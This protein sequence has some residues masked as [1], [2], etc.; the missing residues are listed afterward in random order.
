MSTIWRNGLRTALA[1]VLVAGGYLGLA[2]LLHQP[3]A[4]PYLVGSL[5]LGLAVERLWLLVRWLSPL[6]GTFGDPDQEVALVRAVEREL[7]RSLRYKAPLVVVAFHGRRKL[8]RQ[9]VA[10]MLRFSDIVIC[11]RNNHIVV[12]MT[13]TT[14]EKVRATVLRMIERLPVRGAAIA[15]EHVITPATSLAGFGARHHKQVA[16]AHGPT[17]ALLQGLRLGVFRSEAR[18]RRNRPATLYELSPADLVAA[19][20]TTNHRAMDDLTQHI[21]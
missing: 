4:T 15:D 20:A 14:I 21:A 5:L 9:A 17:L 19:N 10:A 13:E 7:S 3:I 8:T 11:G 6:R 1:L 16:S 18:S 12:L 2:T